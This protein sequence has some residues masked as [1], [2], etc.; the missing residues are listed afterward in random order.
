MKFE[1]VGI[2][3]DR[4]GTVN[5]EVDYLSSPEEL[6]LIPGTA[7]AIREANQ[8]G[9]KVFVITNQSGIARG[10]ITEQDLRN[11][12][13]RL[14]KMLSR[15]GAK[16]DAIYYCPHHSE[17]GLP[18]YNVVCE[19]RK[20]GT[21]MLRTAAKEFGVDLSRSFVVGDKLVDVMAGENAGCTS[22]LVLTGYGISEKEDCLKETNVAHIA[23]D[24]SAAWQFIKKQLRH[25]DHRAA[26]RQAVAGG[27][28]R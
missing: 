1:N 22:I 13:S 23:E 10:L 28:G 2:F 14:E 15:H 12:H 11:I 25:T 21:G 7:E 9:V 8:L 3:F 27:D 4:D 19:C 5:T 18:P 17:S 6:E 24:A 26:K 20:P 16:I